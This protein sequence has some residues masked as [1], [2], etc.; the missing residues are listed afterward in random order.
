MM[1]TQVSPAG[2]EQARAPEF[3]TRRVRRFYEQ[4]VKESWGGRHILRGRQ[5]GPGDVLLMSNDYLCL[6]T[7]PSIIG[8]QV[9]TL[10]GAGNAMLMS[11]IFLH[12]AD[13]Q[14]AL[15]REFAEFLGSESAVLCQ[16]G[17]A[18]NTGLLQAIADETVPVYLDLMAHMS[19]WEGV[20]SA[21]AQAHPFRHNDVAH[22][23][24][25]IRRHGP[26]V[27][28][29]D[30]IYSTNGSACPLA[31]MAELAQRADC[32][33]VVDESHSLGTHGA[34][35]EGLV[36]SLGLAE[37]VH[38]VTASLAKAFAGRA[39]L[40]TCPSHFADYFKFTSRPAIF[41]STL[42]PHEVAGLCATLRVVRSEH[43]RRQ[44]LH[45]NAAFLRNGLSGLGYN[46]GGCESQIIA[47]EAGA[48]G[49]TIRLRD[50]LEARGVFGAVFCAPATAANRS[51]VRL[52]VNCGLSREQLE[53]ILEVCAQIRSEVRLDS[54]PSTRR[55]HRAA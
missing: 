52:S 21:G 48:E 24:S 28:V 50:A 2:L 32:V 1:S 17:F 47:L 12:G 40:I 7:H 42:L 29:V 38:F 18:A 54:W 13:P 37:Q 25:L 5:P 16:S 20:R 23:E 8:A 4:R 51:M 22:L 10:A 26:G 44:R 6:A 36:A 9:E 39:G 46:L 49:D 19:L 55:G 34:A 27:I 15:E 45:E 53:H 14:L 43:W 11:G 41:S 35:G 30:S 3:L 33:L 31:V